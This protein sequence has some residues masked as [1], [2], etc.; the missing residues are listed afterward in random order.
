MPLAQSQA[1]KL[2]THMGF[3][4]N[5]GKNSRGHSLIWTLKGF[6]YMNRIKSP[7][8]DVRIPT[9]DLNSVELPD[10]NHDICAG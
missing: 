9:N 10:M 3:D 4:E 5:C 1:L 8:I 7:F 6:G 2:F